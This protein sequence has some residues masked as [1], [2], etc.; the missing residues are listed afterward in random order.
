MRK[1]VPFRLAPRHIDLGSMEILFSENTVRIGS[2]FYLNLPPKLKEIFD[3]RARYRVAYGGRGSGKSYTFALMTL[4][5][6]I[7]LPLRILCAR[8]LQNSIKDSVHSQIAEVISDN[9]WLEEFYEVGESYIRGYNGTEYIF[10]GLRS[11]YREVKSITGIDIAWIEEAEVVAE[12]SWEVLRPTVRKEGSEI[13]ITFNPESSDSATYTKYVKNTPT[14]TLRALVNFYDNPWFSSTLE[15]ERQ[16]CLRDN[17]KDYGHIW[18]GECRTN[19]E[20]QILADKWCVDEFTPTEDWSGPYFG[21]DWGFSTDPTVCVKLWT[22]DR[23]LFVEKE[24][25]LY[26]GDI[27]QVAHTWVQ[28]IGPE[29]RKYVIKADSS[30]PQTIRDVRQGRTNAP[31]V[32]LLQGCLKWPG[33]VEDGINHL[34]NYRKIIIHPRCIGSQ[35]ECRRYSYKVDPQTNRVTRDIIDD[36]NHAIDAWRYALDDIIRLGSDHRKNR[37][38]TKVR[39]AS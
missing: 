23:Y 17:P 26:H 29:V 7:E 11:N 6:G 31:S 10:K 8:E 33:S 14:G 3:K 24:S 4:V 5:R 32:P 25:Y 27:S 18:L 37:R 1:G 2:E 22:W 19:S 9:P 30:Q 38:P 12:R 28:D 36:F 39:Y 34:R 35:E 13:W 21:A 16:D 20:A 15:Q